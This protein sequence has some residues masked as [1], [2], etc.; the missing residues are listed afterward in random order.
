MIAA[1][2]PSE[3]PLDLAGGKA[4]PKCRF[5]HRMGRSPPS[6]SFPS[7]NITNVVPSAIPDWTERMEDWGVQIKRAVEGVSEMLAVGLGLERDVLTRA[8]E[9]GSHLLAPTATDL[10]KYGKEGESEAASLHLFTN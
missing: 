1:L 8:A 9:F 10:K 2:D 6:T 7:L 5:F 4:D 3:R